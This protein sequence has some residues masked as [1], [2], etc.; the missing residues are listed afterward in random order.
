MNFVAQILNLDKESLEGSRSLAFV[1][2]YI[3]KDVPSL[4]VHSSD[5][6]ATTPKGR[7]THGTVQIHT[8]RVKTNCRVWGIA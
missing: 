3:M 6:V 7:H 4:E 1:T 2:Q 5:T 8:D